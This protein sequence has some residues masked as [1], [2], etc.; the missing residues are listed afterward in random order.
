VE[1]I[2][3]NPERAGLVKRAEEWLWPS[4]HDYTGGLRVTFRP[5]R[6]LASDHALLP[7]DEGDELEG[8]A[9]ESLKNETLRYLL[10]VCCSCG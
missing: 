8:K 10:F 5:N 1:Y 4:V 6:T 7:A 3:L 9:A 2:R